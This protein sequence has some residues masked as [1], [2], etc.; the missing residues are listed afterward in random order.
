MVSTMTASGRAVQLPIA[1]VHRH[2][3][4]VG[5]ISDDM[6]RARAAVR[7]ITM[8][9][10]AYGQLCQFL[11]AILSPVFG[12]ATSLLSEASAALQETA[13]ALHATAAD[14]KATDV[15]T[16]R[17]VDSTSGLRTSVGELPL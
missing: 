5:S 7:E 15:Y 10:E 11:P 17:Q 12:T 3:D 2:A 8:D 4:T 13:S 6:A 1:S 16:A 14:A 9:T